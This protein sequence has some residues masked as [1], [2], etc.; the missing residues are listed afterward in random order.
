MNNPKRNLPNSEMFNGAL[1]KVLSV[2]KTD[3]FTMLAEEKKAKQGKLKPGP[4]PRR[5]KRRS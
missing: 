1:R 4:K 3:L 5:S 2:S